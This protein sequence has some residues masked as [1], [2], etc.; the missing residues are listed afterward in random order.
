M[1]DDRSLFMVVT[2]Y[3]G[4]VLWYVL[5][6]STGLGVLMEMGAFR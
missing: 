2:G 5:L 6:V 3:L 4:L 1:S